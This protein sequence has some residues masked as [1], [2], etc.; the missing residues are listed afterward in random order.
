MSFITLKIRA[1]IGLANS[2]LVRCMPGK[3]ETMGTSIELD[4]ILTMNSGLLQ[5]SKMTEAS[6]MVLELW[7]TGYLIINV[8]TSA[9]EWLLMR[10][11]T[12]ITAHGK[13]TEGTNTCTTTTMP[14]PQN[15]LKE[16][17]DTNQVSSAG[18]YSTSMLLMVGPLSPQKTA[19]G[20]IDTET[21]TRSC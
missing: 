5:D 2:C 14:L 3:V 6:I 13:E 12:L 19:C 7:N 21:L 16:I 18:P 20:M 15:I 1:V 4:S 11:L 9:I 8:S 10:T 17:H